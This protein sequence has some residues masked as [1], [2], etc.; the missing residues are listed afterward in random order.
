MVPFQVFYRG[1]GKDEVILIIWLEL[2]LTN[3]I[4]VKH[5]IKVRCEPLGDAEEVIPQ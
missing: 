1:L 3:L 4:T 5:D 2:Q